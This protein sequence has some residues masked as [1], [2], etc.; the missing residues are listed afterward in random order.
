MCRSKS[1]LMMKIILESPTEHRSGS[2]TWSIKLTKKYI[3]RAK[4]NLRYYYMWTILK[5]FQY[6]WK[7][8]SNGVLFRR[9]IFC[10]LV[11]FIQ[12]S[13]PNYL[14]NIIIAFT[15]CFLCFPKLPHDPRG[16]SFEILNG[17]ISLLFISSPLKNESSDSNP[18][19]D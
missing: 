17:W 19:L 5:D 3:I 16:V 7:I 9:V 6:Y 11:P 4:E 2:C 10:H 15:S 1:F 12:Y 8:F 14:L 18:L 13:Y